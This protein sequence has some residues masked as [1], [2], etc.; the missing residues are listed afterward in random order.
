MLKRE[1]NEARKESIKKWKNVLYDDVHFVCG[2]CLLAEADCE[3]CVVYKVC[4]K[5]KDLEHLP[6]EVLA[7]SILDWLLWDCTWESLVK[8]Q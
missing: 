8:G 1:F 5:I 6:H 3:E 7:M 2:F 4:E